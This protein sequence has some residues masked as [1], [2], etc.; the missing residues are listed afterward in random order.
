MLE[1]VSVYI[2]DNPLCVAFDEI[3][4]LKKM[5]NTNDGGELKLRQKISTVLL[6]AKGG[7][8]FLKIKVTVPDNYPL[9]AVS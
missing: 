2:N 9:S 7:K 4:N 6:T 5:L 8:Y 3:A 1:F